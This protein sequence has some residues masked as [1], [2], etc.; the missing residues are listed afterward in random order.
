MEFICK[1][2]HPKTKEL[3]VNIY[4]TIL[5][6]TICFYYEEH[7]DFYNETWCKNP[8]LDCINDANS[9]LN[10]IYNGTYRDNTPQEYNSD[11]FLKY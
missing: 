1:I 10:Q 4:K 3:S 11:W 8:L 2:S 9:H 7:G 6:N 5:E